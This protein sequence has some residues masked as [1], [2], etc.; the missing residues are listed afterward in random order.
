MQESKNR[1]GHSQKCKKLRGQKRKVPFSLKWSTRPPTEPETQDL[2][3]KTKTHFMKL[4]YRE[5]EESHLLEQDR[6]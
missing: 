6:R 1:T 4:G 3:K 5:Q 2:G